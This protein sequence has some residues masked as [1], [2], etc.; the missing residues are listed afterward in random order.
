M[1]DLTIDLPDALHK[2]LCEI[3]ED[4]GTDAE[5]LT[6]QMITLKVGFNPSSREKPISTGFLKRQTEDVLSV[7]NREPVFFIDSENREFVVVSTEY[8]EQ[9]QTPDTS[10][11]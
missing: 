11:I 5:A 6:R 1:P 4:E 10:E 3:A 8:Y 2:R 9:H 7:A